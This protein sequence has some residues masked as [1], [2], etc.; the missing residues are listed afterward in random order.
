MTIRPPHP[1]NLQTT[2]PTVR[3]IV[4]VSKATVI[5]STQNVVKLLKS[6][7]SR[8][9]YKA[10]NAAENISKRLSFHLVVVVV[11]VIV[12]L[13][14]VLYIILFNLSYF[15]S[16]FSSCFSFLS[17]VLYLFI[18]IG[19]NYILYFIL[20]SKL[21]NRGVF[22]TKE[23]FSCIESF[24]VYLNAIPSYTLSLL[25]DLLYKVTYK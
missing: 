5:L 17:I 15:I 22:Y 14:L 9:H 3:M 21:R 23:C 20:R 4:D 11:L 24:S 12:V 2:L 19:S 18:Y 16:S 7:V 13:V 1:Q 25:F 6:K 8:F 10:V